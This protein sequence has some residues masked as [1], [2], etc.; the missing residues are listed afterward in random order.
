MFSLASLSFIT[1][2]RLIATAYHI[3]SKSLNRE[4]NTPILHRIYMEY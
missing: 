4:S 2:L 3:T 1:S